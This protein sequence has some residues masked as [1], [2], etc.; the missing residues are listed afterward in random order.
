MVSETIID[1]I[2]TFAFHNT[3]EKIIYCENLN[4]FVIARKI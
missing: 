1:D 2:H 3:F 4:L